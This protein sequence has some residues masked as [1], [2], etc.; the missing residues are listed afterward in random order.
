[1][2]AHPRR[3]PS[4]IPCAPSAT[5]PPPSSTASSGP[6]SSSSLLRRAAA[7][8]HPAQPALWRAGRRERHCAEPARPRSPRQL[9]C[10]AAA[11]ITCGNT[12]G[13]VTAPLDAPAERQST[14]VW[15]TEHGFN[16]AELF[17]KV[18]SRIDNPLLTTRAQLFRSDVDVLLR[19]ER[20]WKAR[21]KP[22]PLDQGA[23][24]HVELPAPA[25]AMHAP[26]R[27]RHS[28]Q[29]AA[30]PSSTCSSS[31]RTPRRSS[32]ACRHCMAASRLARR[33]CRGTRR[34][35]TSAVQMTQARRTT[36]WRWTLC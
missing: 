13:A 15:A 14:R 17:S 16:A 23:L 18:A 30:S 21:A 11:R 5:R 22:V 20:L 25:G 9:T 2:N 34:G 35:A 1:M 31:T 3:R 32:A 8:H 33:S 6:N 27:I 12:D 24:P 4:S 28:T 19:M 7:A 10:P 36:M 29:R 26:P